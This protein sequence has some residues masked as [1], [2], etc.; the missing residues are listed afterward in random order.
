MHNILD[1]RLAMENIVYSFAA[2]EV[3][4]R[5]VLFR[6]MLEARWAAFFDE[7]KIRWL[8]EPDCSPLSCGRY[9]PDFWLPDLNLTVEIKPT[10]LHGVDERYQE[11]VEHSHRAFLLIAG[12]PNID[13]YK[14]KYFLA[15]RTTKQ[16]PCV[17]VFFGYQNSKLW[18][19]QDD[20]AVC[21][22]T[23]G[24]PTSAPANL[25]IN[26]ARLAV[27][28]Q[29]AKGTFEKLAMPRK[30]KRRQPDAPVRVRKIE[31]EELLD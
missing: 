27:A 26:P 21:L 4:Y 9:T 19:S 14:L 23:D 18:L 1:G 12:E 10:T 29:R 5:G 15:N 31:P 28:M 17:Q 11:M 2:T 8:Y 16:E 20:F 30:R 3:Y 24:Q 25:E 13:T 6:S 7:F 22:S